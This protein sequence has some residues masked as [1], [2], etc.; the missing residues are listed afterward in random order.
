MHLPQSFVRRLAAVLF[1]LAL[2][3]E[4]GA[5]AAAPGGVL[6]G[7]VRASDGLGLPHVAV[8]IEGPAGRLQVT[9]D[10]EGRFRFAGLEAGVYTASV[11]A[12]GF[13]LDGVTEVS[14]GDAGTPALLDLVLSPAPV[15]EHVLV[16]AARGEAVHSNLGVSTS[17]LDG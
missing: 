2:A 15:R 13:V 17:V 10:A 5:V 6:E 3:A 12:P 14:V 7:S 4:P 9:T 11:D 16:T 8:L 1:S